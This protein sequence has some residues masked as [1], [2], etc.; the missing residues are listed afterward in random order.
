MADN[1]TSDENTPDK[2]PSDY[3]TMEAA[4]QRYNVTITNTM[5][6]PDVM[7]AIAAFNYNAERMNEGKAMHDSVVKLISSQA[8]EKGEAKDA[9]DK[10]HKLHKNFKDDFITVRTIARNTFEDNPNAFTALKLA[11]KTKTTISKFLIQ[12]M[13]F[14]TNL[15]NTPEFLAKIGYFGYTT[16]KLSTQQTAVRQIFDADAAYKKEKGEG[17]A[18]TQLRDDAFDLLE[19]WMHKFYS[20]AGPALKARPDLLKIIGMA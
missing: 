14:Y 7:N 6:N 2:G 1:T 10:L 9:L 19:E 20:V 4:M 13:P 15:L 17:I 18:A 11:G 12:A 5:S 8:K 16:E 3:E